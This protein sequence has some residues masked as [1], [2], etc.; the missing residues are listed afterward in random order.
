M[1]PD[2]RA[3]SPAHS[4]FMVREIKSG[5]ASLL[6][7]L[8]P[9]LSVC[10]VQFFHSSRRIQLRLVENRFSPKQ[11]EKNK[12]ISAAFVGQR[13]YDIASKR[14]NSSPVSNRHAKPVSFATNYPVIQH[15]PKSR[16]RI[17]SNLS[18]FLPD[19]YSVLPFSPQI[20]LL[21]WGVDVGVAPRQS[22]SPRAVGWRATASGNHQLNSIGISI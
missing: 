6:V 12:G 1:E 19:G 14:S 2:R 18:S 15:H 10:S 13:F 11:T 8:F 20:D 4:G 3:F 21:L 17:L 7:L 22:N 16:S 5:V 9:F